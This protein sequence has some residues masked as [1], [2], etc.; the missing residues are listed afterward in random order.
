MG[1]T[2]SI[3]LGALLGQLL[4]IY[5]LSLLVG[6]ALLNVETVVV[7]G[8]EL[9]ALLPLAMPATLIGCAVIISS[10]LALSYWRLKPVFHVLSVNAT[11]EE[12][13]RALYLLFNLPYVLLVGMNGVG[14]LCLIAFHIA[15]EAYARA[16]A[17][18]EHYT[19]DWSQLIGIF[20]GELG[21][22]ILISL[23]L[24]IAVRRM[25]QPVIL[26]FQPPSESIAGRASFAQPLL[27]TYAGTFIA[28][29]L[30]LFQLVLLSTQRKM[31]ID[32]YEFIVE[33]LFYFLLGMILFSYVTIEFRHELRG[34]IRN[35]RE[36]V[37]GGRTQLGGK[38]LFSSHDEAVELAVALNELQSRIDREYEALD[39]ELK[40]AYNVQQKLLPPG[41]LTIGSFR[42][43]ARY[44]PYREVG[45]DFFDVVPLGSNRFAVMI[46]DVSGKGMPAAL[47]MSALLILFRSEIKRNGNPG[48][49]LARMNR[50]LC[51]AMGEEGS[52]SIGLGVIDMMSNGV[53]YASAGH[54]SP[55]IIKPDGNINAINC[56]SLPIGFDAEITYEVRTLQL[57]PGDRFVL[58]TD[59]LIELMDETGSMYSFEGLEAELSTWTTCKELPQMIDEWLDRMDQRSGVG[60]DDRTVVVL[61]LAHDF[62]KPVGLPGSETAVD[63]DISHFSPNQFIYREWV[64]PSKLGE[65]RAVTVQLGTWIDKSWPNSI[66]REDIESAIAEALLNAMEHGNKLN[67]QANVT[68]QVQIG[69]QLVVCKVY[70]EGGGYFPR[71]SR[72]EE[73]MIRTHESE[74]PRGWGLVMIDSLSDYW[75]TSRDE[76][77]F[78]TELYFLRK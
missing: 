70:D 57:E 17:E 66:V 13:H 29:I 18:M 28:T 68:L 40:L 36:L 12:V 44:R 55:Y 54:L 71:V 50:Q 1:V 20:A 15:D 38:M 35:I 33:A 75:A 42:I 78:Y 2:R 14:V 63:G 46:G 76:S 3:T 47:L 73:E 58:Y 19:V 72:S 43:T 32:P 53:Q 4:I 21:I 56:S 8:L 51:E 74:D 16:M 27:I 41:D 65:E 48:E 25:L 49:V 31:S 37:G 23:L 22:I 5:T 11:K 64:I 7:L 45:G 6:I 39:R 34:L 52:V 67:P 24:F 9:G 60:T 61:E 77:G 26:R 69:S 10:L 30:N 62:S 59:G